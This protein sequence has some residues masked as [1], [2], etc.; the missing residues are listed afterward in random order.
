MEKIDGRIEKLDTRVG[1][2]EASLIQNNTEFRLHIKGLNE[3]MT[4]LRADW[5]N[6]P[7]TP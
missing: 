3:E 2:I 5:R 4:A 1:A 7:R 6:L